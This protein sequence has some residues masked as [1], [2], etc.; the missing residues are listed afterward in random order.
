MNE[1]II[2]FVFVLVR[3]VINDIGIIRGIVDDYIEK[4]RY[5]GDIMVI[6]K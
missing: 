2:V 4:R 3:L 1:K 5:L 6:F